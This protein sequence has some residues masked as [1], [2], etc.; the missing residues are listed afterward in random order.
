MMR[1]N[2]RNACGGAFE[3]MDWCKHRLR[4]YGKA[5]LV[6]LLYQ[7]KSNASKAIS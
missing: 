6:D 5:P 3:E 1:V 2:R 7:R 4:Y